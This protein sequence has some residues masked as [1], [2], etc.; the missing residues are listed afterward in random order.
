MAIIRAPRP[1]TNFYILDKRISEDQRL[2][3]GARGLLVFLLGKPDHW[4]VSV[5]NLVNET[6]GSLRGPGGHT[7]RDGVKAVLAELMAAGYLTRSDKP[8]HNADGSFAGYDYLVSDTPAAPV[9]RL[10][11]SPDKPSTA[12]PSTA[13]PSPPNP[14]QVSTDVKQGLNGSKDLFGSSGDAG[15]PPVA[16]P[17]KPAKRKGCGNREPAPSSAAW[18]A[19]RAAYAKR[20]SVEPL[21]NAKVNASLKTI[22]ESVGAEKAP[23]LV[24]HYLSMAGYYAERQHDIGVLVGDLQ[25]VWNSMH[26]ATAPMQY[27]K[28]VTAADF[29]AIDYRRGINADGTF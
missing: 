18:D 25:K 24:A 29:H 19:Y 27:K 16:D 7:K 28:P 23:E 9:D 21:R 12:Q 26:K 11:P 8:K 22:V 4:Q 15:A 17:E 14:T 10:L 3:W 6:A 5:A 20:Y 13:E 2:S 1:D